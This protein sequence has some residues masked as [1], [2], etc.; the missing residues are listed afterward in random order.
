[1]AMQKYLSLLHDDDFD[2]INNDSWWGDVGRLWH[3]GVEQGDPAP[4]TETEY[5]TESPGNHRTS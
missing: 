3:L 5:Q 4:T 1:M 2:N